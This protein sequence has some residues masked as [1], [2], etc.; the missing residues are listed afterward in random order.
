MYAQ[1]TITVNNGGGD[2]NIWFILETDH[3]DMA[4]LLRQMIL[5]QGLIGTRHETRADNA[6]GRRARRITSSGLGFVDR[7]NIVAVSE[8][9]TDLI[10]EDGEILF[11][12]GEQA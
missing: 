7:K 4:A 10:D 11:T 1:V 6:G 2:R 5:D 3:Q 12:C 9:Q 8:M